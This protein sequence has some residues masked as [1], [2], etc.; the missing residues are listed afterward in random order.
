MKQLKS[1]KVNEFVNAVE[2]YLEV[3]L[4]KAL[5]GACM[6]IRMTTPQEPEQLH[7]SSSP[8]PRM[9]E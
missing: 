2:V 9:V 7:Q 5:N 8:I 1:K 3:T 6:E 4:M